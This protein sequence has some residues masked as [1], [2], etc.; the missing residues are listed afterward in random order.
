MEPSSF[1]DIM[2]SVHDFERGLRDWE[3][4]CGLIRGAAAVVAAATIRNVF[5]ED[6]SFRRAPEAER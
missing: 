5:V 6:T 3:A 1:T 2:V 4:T